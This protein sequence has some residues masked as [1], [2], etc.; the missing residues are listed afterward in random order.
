[1][2]DT[3]TSVTDPQPGKVYVL[4]DTLYTQGWSGVPAVAEVQTELHDPAC[5]WVSLLRKYKIRR[6]AMPCTGEQPEGPS[7]VQDDWSHLQK[8]VYFAVRNTLCPTEWMDEDDGNTDEEKEWLQETWE[9]E[10]QHPGQL[11]FPSDPLCPDPVPT[12]RVTSEDYSLQIPSTKWLPADTDATS[13]PPVR[14]VGRLTA[15]LVSYGRDDSSTCELQDGACDIAAL[16]T[17]KGGEDNAAF[18]QQLLH[19]AEAAMN[20]EQIEDIP[21]PPTLSADDATNVRSYVL[22]EKLI[23]KCLRGDDDP[24]YAGTVRSM[25]ELID[26]A[27]DHWRLCKKYGLRRVVVPFDL[28]RQSLT[29]ETFV[30]ED[31]TTC[32]VRGW[33]PTQLDVYTKML[34]KL[35]P[36]GPARGNHKTKQ[37]H[38]A[39]NMGWDFLMETEWPQCPTVGG[40]QEL[41]SAVDII[42]SIKFIIAHPLCVYREGNEDYDEDYAEEGDFRLCFDPAEACHLHSLIASSTD[43]SFLKGLLDGSS[44]PP[45]V[46]TAT[47]KSAASAQAKRAREEDEEDDE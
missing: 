9:T 22:Q 41:A 16:V 43:E 11:T 2:T 24:N 18:L 6:V 40:G 47:M 7:G 26:P 27:S 44:P 10:R 38:S 25:S 1:M 20:G 35:C 3:D 42:D 19:D 37:P 32:R 12:H 17:A 21:A 29:E 39:E 8:K 4:Y 36:K 14:I 31:G 33:T 13:A 23:V 46:A 30:E 45:P 15:N 5:P 34:Q 28:E